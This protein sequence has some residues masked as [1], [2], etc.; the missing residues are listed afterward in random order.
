MRLRLTYVAVTIGLVSLAAVPAQQDVKDAPRQLQAQAGTHQTFDL[1]SK[2]QTKALTVEPLTCE[3]RC[4]VD[5]VR[6]HQMCVA[7]I[8]GL[9]SPD[10]PGVSHCDR[11]AKAGIQQCRMT[12]DANTLSEEKSLTSFKTSD[13]ARD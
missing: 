3:Q 4:D 9:S 11:A 2:S 12:C 5:Y 7:A 10:A 1:L 6:T 13:A 8:S